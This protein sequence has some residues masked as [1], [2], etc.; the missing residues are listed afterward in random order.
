MPLLIT[1]NDKTVLFGDKI[2]GT[3][4]TYTYSYDTSGIAQGDLA[5]FL[6]NLKNIYEPSIAKEIVLIDDRD[7]Y[8]GATL[9]EADLA[10]L[11][12]IS[13]SRGIANG[14][15]GIANGSRGIA[16]GT[17]PDTTYV[18]DITYQSL[19]EYNINDSAAYLYDSVLMINGSRGIVNG[20]RG[21]VNSESLV[22]GSALINGSRGIANG[23]RGIANGSRGIVNNEELDGV[24]NTNTAVIIHEADLDTP[25][26][27]DSVFQLLSIS[28]ISG[29]T[30]GEHWIV[31]GG[32]LSSNFEV[33]Y[34]LGHLFI[35]PY[36]IKV[37]VKDT[38]TLYGT[39]PSFTS[40]ISGYQYD[41]NASTVFT[42]NIIYT[43]PGNTLFTVGTHTITPGGLTL[44]QPTNYYLIYVNGILNV[45]PLTEYCTYGQG[46]W[47]NAGN[48]DCSGNTVT[49][50]IPALLTTAL[51]NGCG[52]RKIT[53]GTTEATCL[54]D[55]LP[56]GGPSEKLPVGDVSCANA[57]GNQYLK[58]G[59]F[60][61]NLLGQ[62]MALALSVRLQPAL[63]SLR[64][65]G[66]FIT[67]SA[68]S[69]CV[70]GLP[71]QGT[72]HTYELKKSVINYL[73][74]NNTVWDLIK[75]ANQGLGDA[76]PPHAPSLNDIGSTINALLNAFANCKILDGFSNKKSLMAEVDEATE[77][78]N[79]SLFIHPNPTSGNTTISFLAVDGNE[80]TIDIYSVCGSHVSRVLCGTI[81]ENGIYSVEVDCS[82]FSKGLYFIRLMVD[83]ETSV[84]K[85]VII[86]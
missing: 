42:G 75:I 59:R 27:P 1:P 5:G 13:G 6:N 4:F 55:K 49:T 69:A 34:G 73:S 82:S 56:S 45:T 35:D 53:I 72:K 26:N 16:N 80:A 68:A 67:T 9:S 84:G 33:H 48:M 12:F 37:Q 14:S 63:G 2:D 62:E 58:N 21:I 23:S 54:I 38:S 85:L 43:P 51:V 77:S 32:F 19:F 18:V 8:N 79:N 10:N 40:V 50:I 64:I 61:S 74:T 39:A 15:R 29:L 7:L 41:D 66:Q 52:T 3:E 24:S 30:S 46:F 44:I 86:Q 57:T 76:L 83:G 20:S 28:A 47:G 78:S 71:V 22:D 36:E 70:N 65:T 81:S 60:K 17:T 25:E 11:A 31:P